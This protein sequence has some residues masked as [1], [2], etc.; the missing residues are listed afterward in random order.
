ME[1]PVKSGRMQTEM[2]GKK[3]NNRKDTCVAESL[4]NVNVKWTVERKSD[5]SLDY[6]INEN[7]TRLKKRRLSLTRGRTHLYF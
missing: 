1:K 3:G 7:N 6:G 4:R 5:Q 2:F